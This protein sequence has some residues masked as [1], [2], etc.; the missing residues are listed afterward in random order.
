MKLLRHPSSLLGIHSFNLAR[1]PANHEIAPQM[2]YFR[3][4]Q[5]MPIPPSRAFPTRSVLGPQ[6]FCLPIA[7]YR[8]VARIAGAEF[9]GLHT[10]NPRT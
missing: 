5:D 6:L 3:V 7:P 9:S 2:D 8:A 4:A 10:Y 1:V